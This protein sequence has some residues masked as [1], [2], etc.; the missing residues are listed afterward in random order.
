MPEDDGLAFVEL[1]RGRVSVGSSEMVVNELLRLASLDR[2]SVV[3]TP[4]IHH[5]AM[6]ECDDALAASYSSAACW[7]AD[8]WPV[9]VVAS[10]LARRPVHRVAGSDLVE[11][12]ARRAAQEGLKVAILGGAGD[13]AHLASTG[14]RLRNP[15][16]C[17][18]LTDPLPKVV[19]EDEQLLPLAAEKVD[20][21]RPE[22]IFLGLGAPKQEL[23]A[24][25]LAAQINS[26]VIVCVG[27]GI[28]FSA[29][30][31]SR[32][33]P[34]LRRVGLEWLHRLLEEPRRLWR[35]YARSAPVFMRVAARTLLRCY[36]SRRDVSPS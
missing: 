21:A 5:I 2:P 8:G 15:S 18:A 20:V 11:I 6:L 12:L 24:T 1:G 22:L 16:L 31:Q 13:A 30:M 9:A 35:R 25:A 34:A 23:F 17:V 26:G 28:N 33:H 4:N 29:G 10:L 3:V 36:I 7:P 32:A 19:V 27:A 14:L